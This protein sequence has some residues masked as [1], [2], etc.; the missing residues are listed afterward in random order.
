MKYPNEGPPK[1]RS[2]WNQIVKRLIWSRTNL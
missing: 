2:L 1:N